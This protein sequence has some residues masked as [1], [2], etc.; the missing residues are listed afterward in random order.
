MPV[1]LIVDGDTVA[2]A[3][4]AAALGHPLRVLQFVATHAMQLGAAIRAGDLVITG[5]CTGL[6]PA[7]LGVEHLGRV[8]GADVHVRFDSHAERTAE[9]RRGK[10]FAERHP[11]HRAAPKTS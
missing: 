5:T 4:G 3:T 10:E 1:E 2:W 7:R 6:V 8:G 11:D 9:F